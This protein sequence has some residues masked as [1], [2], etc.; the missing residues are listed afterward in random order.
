MKHIELKKVARG[1]IFRFRG[2]GPEWVRG[3]YDRSARKYE[4]H[5]YGHVDV[6]AVL[7]GSRYVCI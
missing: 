5:L 2:N 7:D 1:K 4:A 6:R 3:E